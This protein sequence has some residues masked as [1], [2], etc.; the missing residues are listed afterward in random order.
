MTQLRALMR[1]RRLP[2]LVRRLKPAIRTL[3]T[4]E[5]RLAVLFPLLTPV[6][7]CLRERA[8]PVLNAKLDD[9]PLSTNRPV[10][11][12]LAHATV[13]FSGI[14]QGFDANGFFVRF[15]VGLGENGISL[16][17]LP[18]VGQLFGNT[19]LPILGARPVWLGNGVVPPFRPDQ[20][21]MQ[22]APPNLNADTAA[23]PASRSIRGDRSLTHK[24]LVSILRSFQREA[25]ARARAQLRRGG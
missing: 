24:R 12:D 9:G 21:C 19:D 18:G 23:P 1:Q 10:W 3:P 11:Q 6:S 16:G 14:A 7:D 20:P 15:L 5:D 25:K 8:L 4:L 13:G 2:R 17:P 22:Q